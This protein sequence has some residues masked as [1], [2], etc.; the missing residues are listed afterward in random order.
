MRLVLCSS[1]LAISMLSACGQKA[2]S[3]P[4]SPSP[5]PAPEPRTAQPEPTSAPAPTPAPAP[6]LAPTPT[7][8][9]APAPAP[10]VAPAPAPTAP[11]QPGW[12]APLFEKGKVTTWD[13]TENATLTELKDDGMP[14]ETTTKN[15]SGKLTCTVKDVQPSTLRAPDGKGPAALESTITC[16][17]YAFD[18][19]TTAGPEGTWVSDGKSL[20]R[21]FS[22][23]DELRFEAEPKARTE[24]SEEQEITFT[25]DA[26]T[27]TW[28]WKAALL[29]GDGGVLEACFDPKRGPYRFFGFGGSAMSDSKVTATLAP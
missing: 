9:V 18:Y 10:D 14:G 11:T 4:S 29:M 28:C 5:T 24:K 6:E 25:N 26:T 21:R 13:I 16:E 3:P 15:L 17:G 2:A 27:G 8:D 12:W 19:G 1:L 22:D 20:F 7:T 23:L